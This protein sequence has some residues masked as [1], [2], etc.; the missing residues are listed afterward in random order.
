MEDTMNDFDGI[1]LKAI[2][3]G[4]LYQFYLAP[5]RLRITPSFDAVRY[6]CA[7]VPTY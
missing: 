3:E 5:L 7:V 2:E 6:P 4:M 1:K